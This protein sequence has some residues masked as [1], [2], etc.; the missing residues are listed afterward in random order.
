MSGT[1]LVVIETLNAAT[2]FAPGGVRGILDRIA[3]EA[4]ATPTDISTATGRKATA[5]LAYK[6]ARSKTALDKLG[7]DLT[8][9]WRA[10]TDAVNAER[11][12]IRETLD[13]LGDEVRKPLTDWENADKARI[14]A[15][16]AALAA[17]S[18][19]PELLADPSSNDLRMRLSYLRAGSNR[20]WQEFEQRAA[21]SRAAEIARTERLIAD[22]EKREAEATEL[23]RLRAE[24]AERQRQETARLQAEREARIA[25]EAAARA[26]ADAE[27]AAATAARDAAEEAENARLRAEHRALVDRTRI[28]REAA[29]AA[30]AAE[31]ERQA[32][33]HR[34]AQAEAH[35]QREKS[36]AIM[37]AAKAKADADALAAKVEADKLAA[38]KKAERDRLAAIEAWRQRDA[39]ERALVN[40][41][42]DRRAANVAHRT[43]INRAALA[44]LVALGMTDEEGQAVITAI[45]RGEVPHVKMEY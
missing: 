42:A 35:A 14:A 4:R 29:A 23:A 10:N 19:A 21:I 27:Q 43:K 37:A 9:G 17:I 16:E 15:H 6:I 30:E 26:K 18:D 7:K 39:A 1:D 3:A 12:T 24:E 34:A 41:E 22:A 33:E 32:I 40:A 38:E 36:A 25:E 44:A 13:A 28:E 45:A 11:R 8:D 2:V 20:D 31:S 5:A